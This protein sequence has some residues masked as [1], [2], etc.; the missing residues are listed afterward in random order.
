MATLAFL[1]GDTLI[2]EDQKVIKVS[3]LF[4]WFAG[5]F[6]GRRGIQRIL[7]KYLDMDTRRYKVEFQEYSWEEALDNYAE[8]RFS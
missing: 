4:Q 3:R 1:E 2:D 8:D 6:G 5:D 7:R